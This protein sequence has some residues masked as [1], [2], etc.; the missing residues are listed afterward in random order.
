MASRWYLKWA[1]EMVASNTR[2]ER[3]D[4]HHDDF[5]INLIGQTKKYE[6]CLE[7]FSKNIFDVIV[8]DH[9]NLLAES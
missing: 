2:N 7:Q 9:F 6:K 5:S 1:L 4:S 3:F 8:C